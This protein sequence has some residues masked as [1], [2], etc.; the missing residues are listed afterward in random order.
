M[1]TAKFGLASTVGLLAVAA[2]ATGATRVARIDRDDAHARELRFVLDKAAQLGETP[3]A[4][5]SALTPPNRGPRSNV[6]QVFQRNSPRRVF[7][8]QNDLLTDPAVLVAAESRLLLADP[9]QFLLR[10]PRVAAL[11]GAPLLRVLPSDMLDGSSRV[12]RAVAVRGQVHDP[13]VNAEK[14][15]RF[16]R[17]T[18]WDVDARIEVE[19]PVPQ[20]EVDLSLHPVEPLALILAVDQWDQFAPVECEQAD[21][22]E[23]L[24]RHQPL[25]IGHRAVRPEGRADRL[26]AREALDGLPNGAHG[27]LTR[28]AELRPKV[29]VATL[30]DAW[31]REDAS[32]ETSA[33]GIRSGGVERAHRGPQLRRLLRSR[34]Q[35]QL[36]DQGHI[37]SIRIN[38]ILNNRNRRRHSSPQLKMGV[39]VSYSR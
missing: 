26:V 34:E 2:L 29:V 5:S 35:T 19:Q 13:K 9:R 25:V 4:L 36:Q 15:R 7:G 1:Q 24:E 31:S 22:I 27:H 11:H 39:S 37:R 21:G 16:D 12:R 33:C 20:H 10:T 18:V 38:R 30:M 14:V 28:Q 17:R 32:V 3:T 8:G 23:S 6:R